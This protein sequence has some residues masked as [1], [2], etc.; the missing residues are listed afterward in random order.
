MGRDFDRRIAPKADVSSIR[1]GCWASM[2]ILSNRG[3]MNM[4]EDLSVPPLGR[5]AWN[6]GKLIGAK[7][8]LRPKHVWAIRTKLQVEGRIRELCNVQHS[9][10]QQAARL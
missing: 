1:S 6:K 10:R 5:L 8:P 7:P 2:V 4:Q 3:V 9:H